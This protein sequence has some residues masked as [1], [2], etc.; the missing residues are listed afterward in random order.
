VATKEKYGVAILNFYYVK[1]GR[2]SE[3]DLAEMEDVL[4]VGF[5]DNLGM[6]NE[7][8]ADMNMVAAN[9]KAIEEL[10][11]FFRER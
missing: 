4:I 6:Q 7:R 8:I 1:E 11:R 10:K 2:L 9:K 5:I 3:K